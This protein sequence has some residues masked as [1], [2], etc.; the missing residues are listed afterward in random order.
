MFTL[1]RRS[2]NF[3]AKRHLHD[4]KLPSVEIFKKTSTKLIGVES[5]KKADIQMNKEIK[6]LNESK[7]LKYNDFLRIKNTKNI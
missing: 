7:K 2:T 1:I 6:H 4:R 3:V 5:P